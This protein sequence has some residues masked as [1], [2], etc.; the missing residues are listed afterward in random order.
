MHGLHIGKA[1]AKRFT[2]PRDAVTQKL[3]FLGRTGTGKSYAAMK[4][5]EEMYRSGAQIVCLDVVGVW[6]G[7]RL[8]KDG[9]SPGLNI[10]VFGGLRGD[11]PLVPT[12]GAVIADLIVDRRMSVV[13]D[14]SQF[15]TDATKAK[16]AQDFGDRFFRRMK[17]APSP[18]HL[19]LEECQEIV[20][21]NPAPRG[22]ENMMLHY[23]TRMLKLG[24]NFG[25][26]ASL[27][28]QRPQEVNKKAL[29]MSECLFA[30]QMTGQHE[31]KAVRDWLGSKGAEGDDIQKLLRTLEV[32]EAHVSS[33]QWLLFEGIVKVGERRTYD[34]S[35]TPSFEQTDRAEAGELAPIDLEQLQAAMETTIAEAE[36]NDPAILH[37]RIR[38]LEAEI[39]SAPAAGPSEEEIAASIRDS[40][41]REL[42]TALSHLRGKFRTV[43]DRIFTQ[44][45]ALGQAIEGIVGSI[46]ELDDL[47]SDEETEVKAMDAAERP[48]VVPTGRVSAQRA[49]KTP[50]HPVMLHDGLKPRQQGILNALG[51]FEALGLNEMSRGAVAVMSD[52]SPK[53]SAYDKH[54]RRLK[55]ELGLIRYPRSGWITL[56]DEGRVIADGAMTPRNLLGLHTAW[57]GKL[58]PPQARMLWSLVDRY[59]GSFTRPELAEATNQSVKSSAFDKHIRM[60]RSLKIVG[61]PETGSV[62]AT[63]LLFPKGLK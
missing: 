9:S 16:F 11:I 53:S 17:A 4:L 32:G 45:M 38:E 34:S 56:T 61:Y 1:G 60:L 3:A 13:L 24:R 57:A 27:I 63:A 41:D 54:L 14:L 49:P 62:V 40:V 35:S 30:F 39:Q 37:R 47:T 43:V 19:F 21:Q 52:Q 8:A 50:P 10:P 23:W 18:V 33:P 26:G 59:P 44:S 7:L 12:A 42:V 58:S 51:G 5:A 46:E 25:I 2:L 20:P 55:N 28:S 22:G 31:R 48:V 6:W 15:E 29:N 36:A